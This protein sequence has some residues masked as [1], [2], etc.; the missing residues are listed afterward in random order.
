[1]APSP[2]PDAIAMFARHVVAT[3]HGDLPAA[4]VAA[5]KVFLLDTF[6]VAVA[7]SRGPWATELSQCLGR[8]GAAD[9]AR[10]LGRG[11]PLP[12]PAAAM[13]NA[14]QIHN[15]EYDAVHEAAVV[16]P[17]ATVVAAALAHAERQGGISGG[18]L[19][20]AVAL[21]VDVACHIGVAATSPLKFFRPATAGG[22]GATAAVGKLMAFDT[23]TMVA[24]LAIAYSQLGGTMQAHA[25]ASPLLAMQ[26]GFSARHAVAACDMAAAGMPGLADVLAALG[27]VWRITEVAHKPFPSGRATHGVVDAMLTLQ[28]RHGFAAADVATVL[29]EV[30]PL[31]HRLVGRPLPDRPTPSLARL[32]AG[33]VAARALMGGT[34]GLEDFDP[35]ALGDRA[36]H[37][38]AARFTVVADAA[39]D[40]NALAPVAVTVTLEDGRQ[41]A[42]TREVVYGNPANPMSRTAQLDKFHRNWQRAATPLDPAAADRLIEMIDSLETVADVRE[43]VDLAVQPTS[44]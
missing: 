38:L 42:I 10:V 19:I 27:T 9:E 28:Q 18:A 24:A 35:P 22:F 14:Y 44:G 16:H 20:A 39:H 21:G 4:A 26:M 32:C 11:T 25:E 15:S 34:V 17:M 12:A 7:G 31:V 43:V 8:W 2:A 6:G 5:T 29:A 40:A 37:A 41:H 13:A 36:T 1:M 23:D 30:P 33:Y 3:G